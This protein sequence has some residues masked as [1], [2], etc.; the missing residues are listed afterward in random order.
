[1]VTI[2]DVAARAGVSITTVSRVLS[3]GSQPHPVSAATAERVRAAAQELRFVP[4]AIAQG[5]VVRRSHLIGLV[6][7]DLSDPYYPNI[8]SGVE[9][10]ARSAELSVLICNTLGEEAH[11]RD[12]LRVLRARRVDGM[13]VSGG[14]TLSH[15]EL[16]MLTQVDAP[17]VLIGRPN[18]EVELP[19]VSIDNVA[20]AGAATQ[21]LIDHGRTRLAHLAGPIAQSTMSDRLDGFVATVQAAGIDGEIVDWPGSL[22]QAYEEL[23]Q[24]MRT[25]RGRPD[26]IFAA[27][28]R[29]AVAA[30]AAAHDSK[31]DVPR[32]VAVI[33]FDDIPL[34]ALLRPS[35]STVAQPAEQ[36]GETAIGMV[37]ELA[38]GNAV[39]PKILAARPVFRGSTLGVS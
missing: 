21:H 20:A 12:Y 29:L 4:S 38:A 7:P 37:L 35:L 30:M 3:P 8:A 22:E 10:A 1:M 31:L 39:E 16:R 19:Y 17:V 15:R 32:D 34:A 2:A 6:V 9:R 5:L 11:L 14:S 26:G 27:T 36:L 28:D 18:D 33:G 13:V 24:R 25:K 23:R